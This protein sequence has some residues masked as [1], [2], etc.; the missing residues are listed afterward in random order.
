MGD[1]TPEESHRRIKMR[2]RDCESGIPIEYLR[3][4][5]A[6]Y[7][8][9]I[10]DIARVIPV[11]KVDYERFRTAEE[12]AAVIK[13]EYT[14]IANIRKVTFNDILSVSPVNSPDKKKLKPTEEEVAESL[15]KTNAEVC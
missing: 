3:A 11:I 7:E 9:F 5:H 13:T 1:L 10:K 4:L 12:M 14:K 6:A 15:D 2:S 8:V